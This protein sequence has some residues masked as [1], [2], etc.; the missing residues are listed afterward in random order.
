MVR[1]DAHLGGVRWAGSFDVDRIGRWEYTIEAW[2]D[3]YGTWRDELERKLAAGQH[4]LA[5]EM[6]EGIVLLQAAAQNASAKRDRALI[7]HAL[8]ELSENWALDRQPAVDRSI[9]RVGAYEIM[10]APDVP[11]E[12]AMYEAVHGSAPDIAGRNL[13]NPVAL[14]L[15][16]VMMLRGI[17]EPK[18]AERIEKAVLAVLA[19]GKHLTGDL[20]GTATTTQITDAIIEKL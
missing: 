13:A 1:I 11:A 2:T 7:E 12:I 20:G 5:G 6:S 16:G 18:A 9:L 3:V 4:E 10:Y 15:S 8:R 17:G 14:I 19:E